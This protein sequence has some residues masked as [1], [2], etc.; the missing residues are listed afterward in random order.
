MK[1]FFYILKGY[2]LSN[3]KK[4][5][6]GP[7]LI[8]PE[9]V[10]KAIAKMLAIPPRAAAEDLLRQPGHLKIRHYFSRNPSF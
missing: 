3:K 9:K 8:I 1:C 4:A 10:A 5:M 6:N 2:V 7:K